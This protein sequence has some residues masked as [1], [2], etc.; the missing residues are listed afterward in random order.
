MCVGD[1]VLIQYEGKSKPGSYR[2]GMVIAVE[3]DPDG[4]VRTVSVEY[5]LLQELPAGERLLYKGVT[6]KRIRAP[7]QRLV[8][9]LPVEEMNLDSG[10]H[11]GQ[12]CLPGGQAV[13]VPHSEVVHVVGQRLGDGLHAVAEKGTSQGQG[14]GLQGGTGAQADVG[15]VCQHGGHVHCVHHTRV[16]QDPGKDFVTGCIR[17]RLKACAQVERYFKSDDFEA[18]LYLQ[19]FGKFDWS[20]GVKVNDDLREVFEKNQGDD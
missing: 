2:L 17:R 14:D 1:I 20:K 3:K 7:V 11:G 12:D 5:S 8:L 19:F 4:L 16:R 18:A 6:K 15:A 10:V 9:I 13:V